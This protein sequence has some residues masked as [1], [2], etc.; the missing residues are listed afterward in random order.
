MWNRIIF[1]FL[2]FCLSAQTEIESHAMLYQAETISH[3]LNFAVAKTPPP[4]QTPQ[5]QASLD[6]A[7][8]WFSLDLNEIAAPAFDTLNNEPFWDYLREIGVQGIYLKGL[9]QGGEFR[10]GISLDPRWGGNWADLAKI[11]QRKGIALIGDSLGNSTGL[12]AD[13][14]LA[15]KNYG[16]YPGLYHLVEIKPSDWKLLPEMGSSQFSVNIPW[17]M[18]QELQKVG[19]V[20]EYFSAYVKESR[21]N[22]TTQI[23]GVDG[24]QRRWI[25]LKENQCDPVIDWLNP[26]FA[27]YRI[28][29]ADT[30]DSVYNLGQKITR[31]NAEISTNAKETIALWARKLGTYSVLETK[32][33]IAELK[34]TSSDLMTDEMTR[35]ALMHALI[36]ED[37]EALRMMYRLF[38]T[39]G[40]QTKKL[41]HELQPFNEFSCDWAE[42]LA[43]PKKKYTYCEETLTGDALRLRLMKEDAGRLGK[44]RPTTWPVLCMDA[45]GIKDFEQKRDQIA[46]VHLLLAFFYALQPGAFSFSVSDLLGT[47]KPQLL[48]LTGTNENTIYPSLPGQM[49]NPKSF[50]MQLRNILQIRKSNAIE[51]GELIAVPQTK[52]R[53]LIILIHRLRGNRMLQ[54]LAVNFGKTLA[55]QTLEIPEIAQTTAIDLM[56]GL[57]DKKPLDSTSIQ[58]SLPPLTGKVILFQT[59]YHE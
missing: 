29:T 39:E 55:E 31:I 48:N 11:L 34:G 16:E 20:P 24:K 9:K 38:L 14:C 43:N 57:A 45:V 41:V 21:W 36:A 13:F 30:L 5:T 52:D 7:S 44:T 6:A 25:Y 40:I 4:T 26:S 49:K 32:G 12:S 56:S 17:L 22:A 18:L 42:L 1:A 58:L 10:T 27:G 54:L 51:S 19:Y 2:P 53:N 47:L 8:V 3:L 37:A 23:Q 28:A 46:E 15:L 50:A 33:E 59:K 35:S